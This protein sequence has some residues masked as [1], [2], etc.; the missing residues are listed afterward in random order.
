M[1]ADLYFVRYRGPCNICNGSAVVDNPAWA[2]WQHRYRNA[3]GEDLAALKVLAGSLAREHGP[4]ELVCTACNGTGEVEREASLAEALTYCDPHNL[5]MTDSD[6]ER[7]D[8]FAAAA[9]TGLMTGETGRRML[10]RAH[11]MG[12]DSYPDTEG[13]AVTMRSARATAAAAVLVACAMLEQ[14][15]LI[16][17]QLTAD[18]L[19]T[20]DDTT[21][22]PAHDVDAG[23][24]TEKPGVHTSSPGGPRVHSYVLSDTTLSHPVDACGVHVDTHRVGDVLEIG[25]APSGDVAPAPLRPTRPEEPGLSPAPVDSPQLPSSGLTHTQSPPAPRAGPGSSSDGGDESDGYDEPP[26]D[27]GNGEGSCAG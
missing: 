26:W 4:E 24:T 17:Q 13:A 9:L 21:L 5:V 14:L 6:S 1:D 15:T 7:R 23:P 16:E 3:R 10:V 22:E 27:D 2:G 11:H 20:G 12:S 19:E 8:R 18:N 25:S